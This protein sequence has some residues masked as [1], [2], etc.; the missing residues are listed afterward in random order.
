MHQRGRKPGTKVLNS[1]L[2]PAPQDIAERLQ[3]DIEQ[4][5]WIVMKSLSLGLIKGS[6]DQV[7]GVVNVT[8]VMPRVLDENMMKSLAERFGEWSD[9]VGETKDFMGER[10]PAF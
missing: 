1:G 7:D 2:I 5:E 6:M 8:W 3:V 9:K 4:V 10:I